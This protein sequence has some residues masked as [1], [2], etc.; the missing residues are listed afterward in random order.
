LA[1]V[2]AVVLAGVLGLVFSPL[3][4]RLR[5]IYLG[6][7]SLALIFIGQHI[8]FDA[9]S[10]TG[11]F[12]GR[13]VAPFSLG[14]F[15]FT[16]T[17]PTL[18]VLNVPFGQYERLWYLGLALAVL[19]YLFAKN[20]LRGRPGRAM[21]AIRDGEVTAAV[22]GVNVRRYKAGAFVVSSMYA[23]LAGVVFALTVS[24]IV[25]ASFDF[26]LTIDYLAAIVIGGLG[27]VGGAAMGAAFVAALPQL[28]NQYSGAIPFLAAPGSGGVDAGSFA[29]YIYGAAMILVLVFEPEGLAAAGRR[30]SGWRAGKTGRRAQSRAASKAES[31]ETPRTS[32]HASP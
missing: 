29:R 14:G 3:S 26:T 32:P 12:N 9:T 4:S 30:L 22:M 7:A 21:Q 24:H 8:M 1:L 11:G 6:I 16:S 19:A 5:G 18:Y 23:G 13:A 31:Q 10:L 27:S 17:E 28:L 15:S 2:L 25:P 20:L